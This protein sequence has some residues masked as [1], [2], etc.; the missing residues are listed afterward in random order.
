M[1]MKKID[2]RKC[3]RFAKG[4][5]C[6]IGSAA[7]LIVAISFVAPSINSRIKKD[8]IITSAALEKAID[9]EQLSTAEFSYSGIAEKY[10]NENS[11]E[12]DCYIAYDAKVKVGIQLSDIHFKIDEKEKTIKPVLPKPEITVASL[13]GGSLSYIPKNPDIPLKDVIELCTEDA[14]QEANQSERLRLTAQENLQ[15]VI[16]ALLSP[17]LK[18]AGYQIIW[19]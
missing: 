1:R 4:V 16:E 9:I 19:Q 5:I 8:D 12:V 10:K 3:K 2:T 7:I 6:T 11:K 17:I 15:S 14:K 13:D 18:Q